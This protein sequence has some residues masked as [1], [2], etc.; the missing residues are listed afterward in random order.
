MLLYESRKWGNPFA[1]FSF[2]SLFM[3]EYSAE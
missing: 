1:A 2:I 3:Q